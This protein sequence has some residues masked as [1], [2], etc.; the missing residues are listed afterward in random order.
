M[1]DTKRKGERTDEERELLRALVSS[2]AIGVPHGAS[3]EDRQ[4]YAER[5]LQ[6]QE[7]YGQFVAKGPI[8][9]PGTGIL[10]FATGQSVPL[11]HVEKW[12]LEEADVVERVATPELAR[13]GRRSP[14]AG[15][16][17][18][19]SDGQATGQQQGEAT[20]PSTAAAKKSTGSSTSKEK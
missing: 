8:Y 12:E 3:D 20:T 6:Q 18:A 10:V 1:A 4:T 5:R 13:A 16:T 11:E 14:R 2:P 19:D 17:E 15:N 9:W 7:A